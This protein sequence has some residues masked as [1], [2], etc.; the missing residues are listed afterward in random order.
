MSFLGLICA[1]GG[2]KGI[3]RKNVKDIC[4]QPLIAYSIQ[5]A[6]QSTLLSD[7]VVSTD[8]QEIADVA[9]SYGASV[10][11]MRPAELASDKALQIDAIIHAVE[12][13]AAQGK[14]YDYVVLL[15][16]TCPLRDGADID[17]AITKFKE[18]QADTLISVTEVAGYHPSTMYRKN[19]EA[20][21][22]PYITSD[23][24]GVLRQN[25]DQL[26]WRNGAIYILSVDVMKQRRS[27]YGDKVVGFEMP[28]EKSA[29]IDEP[30]DWTIAECLLRQKLESAPK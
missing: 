7:I 26:W 1:R 11:F 24:S 20:G 17:G 6:Q 15:Q 16:P 3:P 30:L 27:L 4:G 13:L 21:L 18:E 14:P 22:S 9:L 2:S 25:F 23:K 12:T 5:A 10:P 29:N 28:A 19:E 8:D